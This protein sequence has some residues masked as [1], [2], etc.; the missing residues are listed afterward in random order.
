MLR[1][2]Q[3]WKSWLVCCIKL[4]IK[5]CLLYYC[6]SI[7][8]QFKTDKPTDKAFRMRAAPTKPTKNSITNG[9]GNSQ[10]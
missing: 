5:V 4:D 7:L 3:R 10:S 8:L 9:N 6:S 1:L 2:S